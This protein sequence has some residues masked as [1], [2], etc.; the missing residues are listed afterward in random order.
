LAS[1]TILDKVDRED[2]EVPDQAEKFLIHCTRR[3]Q[4]YADLDAANKQC[5]KEIAI[6]LMND[7]MN[8]DHLTVLMS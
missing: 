4:S 5:T 7:A 1:L 8:K 3:R 6:K 2:W